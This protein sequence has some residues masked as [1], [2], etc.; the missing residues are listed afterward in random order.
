MTE[1]SVPKGLVGVIV[2]KTAICTTDAEGNLVYRGYKTVDLVN[3]KTFEEV[4][5]LVVHGD[6]PNSNQLKEFN[7]M[8]VNSGEIDSRVLKIIDLLK[9][10]DIMK[11]LRSMISL[12]PY[13]SADPEHFLSEIIAKVPGIIA[14][15]YAAETGKSVGRSEA[16]SYSGRFYQMITGNTDARK[17][18][19][20]SKLMILYMEHEFNASTFV[21]RVA[22]ST[23][24]DPASAFTSA[25]GT[26]K[27][28][29]HGGANAE[30]LDFFKSFRNE[31]E[32]V[33][34]VDAQL[35][36]GKKVMGFGH[37]V[38]KQKDPRAQLVKQLMKELNPDS[39]ELRIAE[40]IEA[41]VWE[42]KHLPANLDFYAAILMDQL[43]I[44]QDL[45]TAIFAAARVFGWW[46]HYEEQLSDN[47]LIRPSS[48]YVGPKDRV[49]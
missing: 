42:K 23:L 11:N 41:R 8:L 38:Y 6:L 2:D 35:E 37:R 49:L 19:F 20:L 3:K 25:L 32:A 26:L 28:P 40:A 1:I 12:Y 21:L 17:S 36:S 5:Y 44:P 18:Q 47:K 15:S 34:F 24:T 10:K 4:A 33:K 7:E 9:E 13:K 31:D 29:L 45:Y 16:S 27:G 48:E 39:K 30:I 22:A 46:A 14:H 43:G